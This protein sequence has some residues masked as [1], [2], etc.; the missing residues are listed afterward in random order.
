MKVTK[1]ER[2]FNA[3]NYTVLILFALT[4]L[5]PFVHIV[6]VSLSERSAVESGH[7]SFWPIGFQLTAYHFSSLPLRL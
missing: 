7:V 2:I 4:C 1:G 3:I 6:A 5:L